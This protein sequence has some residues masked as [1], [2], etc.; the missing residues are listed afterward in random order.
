MA[1]ETKKDGG[2]VL[3]GLL[4]LITGGILF[5]R[6]KGKSNT[7]SILKNNINPNDYETELMIVDSTLISGYAKNKKNA[8]EI[9]ELD[10]FIDDIKVDTIK[11]NLNHNDN[12]GSNSFSYIPSL[13]Q[14]LTEGV[15]TVSVRISNTDY[16]ISNS[17]NQYSVVKPRLNPLPI[18]PENGYIRMGI[19]EQ[20]SNGII[21]GYV[22]NDIPKIK[23]KFSVF[24]NNILIVAD[25][26]PTL[27][28]EEVKQMLL[29]DG[30]AF[31]QDYADNIFGFE[32][33]IPNQFLQFDTT[34][35][36]SIVFSDTNI[37]FE[38]TPFQYY[39]V[40]EI[41]ILPPDGGDGTEP[42]P[43]DD[44]PILN[45]NGVKLGTLVG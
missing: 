1:E 4:L 32:I 17:P 26:Q 6:N 30:N 9:V 45:T 15:H 7:K 21:Q 40:G 2:G 39:L 12:N 31:E 16:N 18:Y 44:K 38:N 19:I 14:N 11:S 29:N 28:R 22:I 41:V 13:S 10:I 37:E 3:L 5:F 20:V 43:N 23:P 42:Q 33:R 35:S 24:I 8:T 36:V 27:A 25:V 34:Y